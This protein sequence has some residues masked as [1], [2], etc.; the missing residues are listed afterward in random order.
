MTTLQD[1]H[2]HWPHRWLSPKAQVRASA[3][4]GTGVFTKERILQGEPVGVLGGVI[5]YRD[6]IGEY[7]AIMTQV[8]IQIDD[9]FFIVPTTREELEKYGVFNHSCSPNIGF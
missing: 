4:Q 3:I 9:N 7:R 2:N 1:V 6:Q 8:G 5:V